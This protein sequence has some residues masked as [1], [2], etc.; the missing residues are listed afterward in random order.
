[1]TM[2][3]KKRLK[4]KTDFINISILCVCFVLGMLALSA[5]TS[6]LYPHFHGYD[7]AIFSLMGKGLTEGKELYVDLF[8]HKGPVIF[9]IN[10]LGN[11]LGGRSGIFVLQCISGFITIVFM[12]KTGKLLRPEGK[13]ATV[14]ECLFI[15]ISTFSIFFFTFEKGNLTEEYSLPVIACALYLFV[16]YALC[17]DE[18]TAHPPLY[19]LI[20]GMGIAYLSFLRLN[21]AITLFAGVAAILV[22]LLLKRQY[23]NAAVNLL[24]GC[25]GIALVVLPLLLY[26]GLHSSL[27]DMLYATFFHNF[28]IAVNTARTNIWQEPLLFLALYLPMAVSLGLLVIKW[29]RKEKMSF[30]DVLLLSVWI[31]NLLVLVISNR[32]PHYFLLFCPVFHVYICRYLK[33]D[34][35]SIGCYLVLLCLLFNLPYVADSAKTSVGYVYVHGVSESYHEQVVMGVSQI[36][37]DERDSIIGYE[38]EACAYL[39]GDIMPCYQYYTLQ[40]TWAVTNPKVLE[41]FMMFL[42]TEEPK[43]VLVRPDEDSES[44]GQILS[45]KYE[46]RFEND[47]ISYYRLREE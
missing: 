19:A 47:Y 1:M 12:Y 16:K 9:F 44:I 35:R 32:F 30:V 38:I 28:H 31:G 41:E 22:Y 15:F 37:E 36:P 23:K 27:D 46:Y 20:Y 34:R 5:Y 11:L 26:F 33:F 8:D 25:V 7:A 17:A 6:P 4:N 40:E 3:E 10:A 43:W 2:E 29:I 14:F 21:N 18:K 13:Y 39:M 45:E 24:W 42:Q